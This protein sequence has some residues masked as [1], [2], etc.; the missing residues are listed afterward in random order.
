MHTAC[1]CVCVCA[2]V[3]VCVCVCGVCVCV[4]VTAAE[5]CGRARRSGSRSSRLGCRHLRNSTWRNNRLC[6]RR[7]ACHARVRAT[8]PCPTRHRA[9]PPSHSAQIRASCNSRVAV[10][11]AAGCP[12]GPLR[13][14]P[15]AR[16]VEQRSRQV[17]PRTAAIDRVLDVAAMVPTHRRKVAILKGTSK[18]LPEVAG[19]LAASTGKLVR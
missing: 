10:R 11:G 1:V 3:C 13:R 9:R 12:Q 18:T 5:P 19:W 4:C 2:R 17:E 16:G 6:S 7:C 8:A 15:L 14:G